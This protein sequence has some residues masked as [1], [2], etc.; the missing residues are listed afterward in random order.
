MTTC[1][2]LEID[3]YV[4][5]RHV[6]SS[7]VDSFELNAARRAMKNLKSLL[8]GQKMYDLI[9]QQVEEGDAYYKDII[10]KSNGQWRECRT[11]MHVK[12]ITATQVQE[13]RKRHIVSMTGE[14]QS[15]DDKNAAGLGMILPAHP[16]HYLVPLYDEG[17]VEVIGEHMARVRIKAFTEVPSFVMEYSDP[18]YPF[19]KPTIGELEDGT[20]LFYILHEFRDTE[21]GC[22]LT[23][24]LLFPTAAPEVWFE[25]HAQHLAIEFRSFLTTAYKDLRLTASE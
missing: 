15:L 25:E 1:S 17:I 12:G 22:D 16:E 18:A 13:N 11:D 8:G 20:A 4:R 23:L 9:R 5:G 19:K 24:R 21:D 10:A 6:T 3:C 14:S 7:Q 2:E